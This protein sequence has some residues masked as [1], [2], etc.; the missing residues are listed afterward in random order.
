MSAREDENPIALGPR[1]PSEP[2]PWEP[3][4]IPWLG[5]RLPFGDTSPASL[6]RLEEVL[7]VELCDALASAGAQ[8][9]AD[10]L[11]SMKARG[12]EAEADAGALRVRAIF[13]G[14]SAVHRVNWHAYKAMERDAATV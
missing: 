7:G 8:R 6:E 1:E 2:K 12:A 14:F 5:E 9:L 4:W 3:L 13:C 10:K 11:E